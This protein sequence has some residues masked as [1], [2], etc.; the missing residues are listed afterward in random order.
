MTGQNA[1]P[2]LRAIIQACCATDAGAS[3]EFLWTDNFDI[4]N[5]H[6]EFT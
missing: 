5:I 4:P 6:A 3:Q 2:S 1:A